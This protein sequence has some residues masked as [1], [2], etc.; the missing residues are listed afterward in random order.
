MLTSHGILSC[1]RIMGGHLILACHT[2]LSSHGVLAWHCTLAMLLGS[3]IV[4][5]HI[6]TIHLLSSI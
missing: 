4:V 5:L 6:C 3:I 2:V 1:H